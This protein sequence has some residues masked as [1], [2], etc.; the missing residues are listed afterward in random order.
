MTTPTSIAISF[1]RASL[2]QRGQQW[3]LRRLRRA[4]ELVLTIV[5]LMLLLVGSCKT[6]DLPGAYGGSAGA[7]QF[8]IALFPDQVRV[9]D[10]EMYKPARGYVQRARTYVSGAPETLEMLTAREV[11]YLFGA[12]Q[13]QRKDA[14][15][16]ANVWQY[17]NGECVV[18]FYFYEDAT[19]AAEQPAVS[20]ADVR[21]RDDAHQLSGDAES[22]CLRA[23][24][25]I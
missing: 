22:D 15:A 16:K 2:V 13:W 14:V 7:D 3:L 21:Q 9:K 17:S 24:M 18:D 23:V 5:P 25:K 20:Y 1:E 10:S 12:P 4:A 11:T 6:A 19:G 8:R